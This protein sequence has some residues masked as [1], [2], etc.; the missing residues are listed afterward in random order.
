MLLFPLFLHQHQDL[1]RPLNSV[2]NVN[3]INALFIFLPD[4]LM[5]VINET[6]CNTNPCGTPVAT[7]LK[8]KHCHLSLPFANV[9]SANLQTLWQYSYCSQSH[10][11]IQVHSW[12]MQYQILY[13]NPKCSIPTE[14]PVG[15]T[16]L[17]LLKP[18]ISV[19]E[20]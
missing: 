15:T 3:S 14:F 5:R 2:L 19:C 17:I 9:L 1:R 7:S 10:L 20:D 12:E 13:G 8:L 6:G 18:F 16:T 11:I 4:Q